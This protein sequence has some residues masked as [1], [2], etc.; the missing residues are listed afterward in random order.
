MTRRRYVP[1]AVIGLVLL[2]WATAGNEDP[3]L[4]AMLF[5][6]SAVWNVVL[7]GLLEAD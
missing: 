5:W 6:L 4:W 3:E 2:G 7:L 1:F